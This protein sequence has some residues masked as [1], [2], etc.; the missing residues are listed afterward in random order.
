MTWQR[1]LCSFIGTHARALQYLASIH[2]RK[3]SQPRMSMF[4]LHAIY[5]ISS[6]GTSAI[7]LSFVPKES[8]NS[9]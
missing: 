3:H 7:A 1:H 4:A 6:W 9:E 5:F 2:T 8:Q